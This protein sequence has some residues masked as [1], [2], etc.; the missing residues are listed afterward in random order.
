[1][2]DGV[3][4]ITALATHPATAARLARK[5]WHFFVTDASDPDPD[6]VRGASSVYLSNQTRIEPVIRYVMQ[7]RWF[8]NP[9]NW[10]SRYSWPVEFAVRAMKEVGYAASMWTA[11]GRR[12]PRWG[13]CCSSRPM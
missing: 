2:Q 10:F 11:C 5:L 12:W 7:S 3:D 1:M 13:R 9:G 6:F 8:Q 4:F